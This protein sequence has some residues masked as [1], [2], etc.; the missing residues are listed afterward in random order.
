ML[1][2]VPIKHE[3]FL[4]EMNTYLKKLRWEEGH[5]Q[6]MKNYVGILQG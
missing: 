3:A 1:H 4:A 6:N 2:N 5:L